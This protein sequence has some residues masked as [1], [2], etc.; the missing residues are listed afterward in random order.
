MPAGSTAS[1]S[2]SFSSSAGGVPS[3]HAPVQ[4]P[5]GPPA[6]SGLERGAGANFKRD[7]GAPAK[8]GGPEDREPLAPAGGV[9]T[10]GRREANLREIEGQFEKEKEKLLEAERALSAKVEEEHKE[11]ES[12]VAQ[13]AEQRQRIGE[14]LSML[15][16][17]EG[18][19]CVRGGCR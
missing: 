12:L 15:R 16:Q 5:L 2:K 10:A 14:L 3:T 18:D 9:Q 8:V 13:V 1:L 6:T 17:A 11:K 19:R 4:V 7:M